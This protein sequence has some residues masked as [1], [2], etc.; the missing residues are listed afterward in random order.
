MHS[1]NAFGIDLLKKTPSSEN[2]VLSP[3]SIQSAL[4]MAWAGAEGETRAEIATALHFSENTD[5]I[6][7]SLAT[8]RV[9]FEQMQQWALEH[10]REW[11]SRR[12]SA[13]ASKDEPTPP[14]ES[15]KLAQEPALTI[16]VANNLFVQSG[17]RF[18][19]SFLALMRE[20]YNALPQEVNFQEHPA[21]AADLINH[22]IDEHT[23]GRIKDLV[24]R[25]A[26]SNDCRL[27]LVNAV[28]FKAAWQDKFKKENTAPG[29]FHLGGGAQVEVP[30]MHRGI[31]CDCAKREDFTVVSLP[32]IGYQFHFTILL[33]DDP[34]GLASLEAKLTGELLTGCMSLREAHKI[35]LWLP[36]F[37]LEPPTLD[38]SQMLCDLGIKTAFDIPKGSA[39]FEGIAARV[40]DDYLCLSAALHKTF[41]S[42]D[43]EGTEAAGATA[44][45][46][47]A[48]GGPPPEV[49]Q[50]IRVDRPFLFAI[51]DRKGVC[52]FLGRVTDPR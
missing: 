28:Y 14:I 1:I 43:E 44:F 19:E 24:D 22:W 8:I 35:K 17:Y 25:N 32:Y 16:S 10:C 11:P 34:A 46:A 12:P 38:L 21:K 13:I 33:P 37:K 40:A 6:H 42:V 7:D 49:P 9:E 26:L 5:A 41:L 15:A 52:L 39:N 2:T 31:Y 18:R 4:A 20:K 50:E 23:C 30:M 51:H 36:K 3:F 45:I 48:G 29:I 27:A 47:I